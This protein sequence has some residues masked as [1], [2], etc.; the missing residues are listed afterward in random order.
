MTNVTALPLPPID[1]VR[2]FA[3]VARANA[4]EAIRLLRRLEGRVLPHESTERLAAQQ[5]TLTTAL[6]LTAIL[7]VALDEH[8][9]N[10]GN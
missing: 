2:A 7:E 10:R 8:P 3:A 5:K 4:E 9:Q 6:A 1:R